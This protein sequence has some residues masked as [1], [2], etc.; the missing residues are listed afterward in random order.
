MKMNRAQ[1]WGSALAIWAC[2]LLAAHPVVAQ[3]DAGAT[4]DAGTTHDAEV[5]NDLD[6]STEPAVD[7]GAGLDPQEATSDAKRIIRI[8]QVIELDT[9]HLR[10]LGS[11]LR[12][13]STWFDDLASGMSEIAVERNAKKE[14]LEALEA[15]P[16]ANQEEV[17]ALRAEVAELNEDYAL[18]DT[19]TDLA[20]RGERTVGDQ[21]EALE[22]K[23]Q[24]E[25]RALGELTGE[26]Q[27]ELPETPSP[28]PDASTPQAKPKTTT[29]SLLPIP[30]P[31]PTAPSTKT[32][33]SSA[34]TTAQL[35]AHNDLDQKEREVQLARLALAEFVE[36]KGALE[37]QIEFEELIAE[38][39][40]KEFDNLTLALEAFEARLKKYQEADKPKS[41]RQRLE[42][43]IREIRRTLD[44][45]TA[46]IEAQ[47][48]YTESLHGRLK[49][50]DEEQLRVTADVDEKVDES[51]SVRRAIVW[52]ESPVHPKN[53]AHWAIDRGPRIILVIFAA[54]FLLIF[55]QFS[56]RGIARTLVRSRRGPRSAGTGRADT[57][58]FSFRSAF[59]VIIVVLGV[60]LVLQE[61]GVD[62]KTVLGGAAILGVAIAFGAQGLMKDYF[63]GFLILLE[64][65]YQLGDLISIGTVTGTV[66]S[67]NMRV[68]VLRDLEG[69]VHFMPNGE[70]AHVTNRT[71]GWGRPVFEIPVGY[72][73]DIDR[74]MAALVDVA[75][76]LGQ[77][78]DWKTSIIGE[79]DMLGVDKF[80]DYGVVIK[81]MVKTQPDKLFAVRREMLHRIAKRFNELGIQI[82]VPQRMLI[83]AAG[84][85]AD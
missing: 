36:R 46:G 62:L 23:L 13:R 10:W 15:S 50:L 24:L 11:E 59:R 74:A 70:I 72:G 31:L 82:T 28:A 60:L 56:A 52:L 44:E 39:Q 83:R 26:I 78:P 58:A 55:V 21:I 57:L 38:T 80:T 37:Q 69:R 6:A 73:E 35:E 29:P 84:E 43:V 2:C 75:K 7:P 81:F 9:E 47:R 42:R 1:T 49:R 63:S 4:S 27:I 54:A 61:G 5:A 65:Q 34:M 19:Q 17:D 20:L 68:T 25:Q 8:R 41:K 79:P 18:F 64:D 76:E 66:E 45:S 33:R 71:Y 53:V 3:Q 48:A 67:V 51:E 30:I 16:Q 40:Q 77:D 22:E 12:A 85:L 14:S 32:T